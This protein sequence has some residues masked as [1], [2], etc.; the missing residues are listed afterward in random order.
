MGID[1][2]WIVVVGVC[3]ESVQGELNQAVLDLGNR[4]I[5]IN[6]NKSGIYPVMNIGLDSVDSDFF[7]FINSGDIL[8][9][10]MLEHFDEVSVHSV[11][12]FESDWHDIDGNQIS[13]PYGR[14]KTVPWLARMPNHQAMVFPKVFKGE[15]YNSKFP[16]AADQDL[17]LKLYRQGALNIR[18]G[19]VV[20]SL[21][22][23][24][25]VSAL[26]PRDVAK[27][28]V[29]TWLILKTH[30]PL[31]HSAFLIFAYFLRFVSRVK[32]NERTDR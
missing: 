28:T 4:V 1:L 19:A 25:S 12:C 30:F 7:M 23:G 9:P 13:S 20:S 8:T 31:Y 16:I 29:E 14:K 24:M 2:R 18:S 15:K 17:K 3:C 6:E 32:L 11:T 27:R 26:S 10:L 5:I 21:V 22:G